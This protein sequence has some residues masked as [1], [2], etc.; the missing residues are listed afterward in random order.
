MSA[1]EIM[2]VFIMNKKDLIENEQ[3]NPEIIEEAEVLDKLISA[4][5]PHDVR[6]NILVAI[7]Q[8]SKSPN[9]LPSP[10]I[11]KNYQKIDPNLVDKLYNYA[12]DEQNHRH[13]IEKENMEI[14]S[15]DHDLQATSPNRVHGAW[16]WL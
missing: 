3:I 8:K 4:D 11:L 13:A 10:D 9:P 15:R 2:G 5:T 6:L 14:I 7:I 1:G 16:S 12:K